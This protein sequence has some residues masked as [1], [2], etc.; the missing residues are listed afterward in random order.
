MPAGFMMKLTVDNP[1]HVENYN[2]SLSA[3]AHFYP[4]RLELANGLN[5]SWSWLKWRGQEHLH[6]GWI[7]AKST[8]DITIAP[9]RNQRS[10]YGTDWSEINYMD[11]LDYQQAYYAEDLVQGEQ[12]TWSVLLE[13]PGNFGVFH[14]ISVTQAWF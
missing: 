3:A 1:S 11:L 5:C 14:R 2:S 9:G 8:A 13:S 10:Y 6:G 4:W 12:D 7:C